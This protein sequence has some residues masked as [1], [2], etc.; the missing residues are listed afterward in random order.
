VSVILVD[1]AC[2]NDIQVLGDAASLRNSDE[3]LRPER[4]DTP[5]GCTA[6]RLATVASTVLDDIA[7]IR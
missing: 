6:D 2:T 7:A 4:E 3:G 1:K 5:T